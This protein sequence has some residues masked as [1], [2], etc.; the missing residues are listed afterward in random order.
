MVSN[1]VYLSDSIFWKHYDEW[2]LRNPDIKHP[3]TA[4]YESI[5]LTYRMTRNGMNIAVIQDEQKYFL[6]KIQYGI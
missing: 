6:A 2:F 3:M 5:G 1:F 4:F